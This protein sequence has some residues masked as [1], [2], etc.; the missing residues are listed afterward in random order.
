MELINVKIA[1]FAPMP[2]AKAKTATIANAGTGTQQLGDYIVELAKSPEY[3]KPG[4]VGKPWR[5]GKV[6]GFQR[7]RLGPWDLVLRALLSTVADRN[8]GAI[9]HAVLDVDL[10]MAMA[11][12]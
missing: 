6:M 7:K 3:A 8:L 2:N 4:N 9:Q 11:K 5:K 10:K 12:S 1:V